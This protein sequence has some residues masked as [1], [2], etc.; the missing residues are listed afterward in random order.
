MGREKD[1]VEKSER[2]ILFFIF[3]SLNFLVGEVG[4]G[5]NCKIFDV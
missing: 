2:I 1:F 3:W 5:F 4:E